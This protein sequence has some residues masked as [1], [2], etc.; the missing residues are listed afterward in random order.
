MK[1][2][3]K[4]QNKTNQTSW[5]HCICVY[6]VREIRYECECVCVCYTYVLQIWQQEQRD[7]IRVLFGE[8]GCWG[9]DFVF[10]LP[11]LLL[12]LLL[13]LVSYSSSSS[14]SSL[15]PLSSSCCGW[16]GCCCG[17]WGTFGSE[18][19]SSSCSVFFCKGGSVVASIVVDIPQKCCY[20]DGI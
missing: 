8:E 9:V 2:D 6:I 15:S 5:A 20:W 14:W 7:F 4:T 17:C 19:L 12:L 11:T 16:G 3:K 18:L 1:R 13:M 10:L